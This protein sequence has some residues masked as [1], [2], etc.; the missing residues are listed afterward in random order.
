MPV[1]IYERVGFVKRPKGPN[2]CILWL[3]KSRENVLS[4]DS[5][6]TVVKRDTKF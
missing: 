5:A 1:E 6:F 4:L 2:R 3:S